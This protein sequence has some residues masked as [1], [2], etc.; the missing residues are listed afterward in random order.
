MRPALAVSNRAH[1]KGGLGVDDR[2]RVAWSPRDK[3]RRVKSLMADKGN[4]RKI[5]RDAKT[6]EFIPIREAQRR[7]A[8]TIIDAIRQPGSERRGK[9]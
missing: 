3:R 9:K 8:T 7:R 1:F 5:G 4:Q 6:G 2:R